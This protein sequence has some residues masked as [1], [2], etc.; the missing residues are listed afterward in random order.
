MC[1]KVAARQ[2]RDVFLRHGVLLIVSMQLM[3]TASP[4]DQTEVSLT[5]T[6]QPAAEICADYSE[7]SMFVLS[8][9]A[10]VLSV[11]EHY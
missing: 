9:V 5:T 3:I 7:Q 11:C 4:D 8:F 1:V 6:L 2:R 10:V